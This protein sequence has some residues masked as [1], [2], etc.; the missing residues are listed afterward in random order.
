[1]RNRRALGEPFRLELEQLRS[2]AT[3]EVGHEDAMGL[4]AEHWQVGASALLGSVPS[5]VTL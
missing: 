3:I 2:L 4:L 5:F 1:M